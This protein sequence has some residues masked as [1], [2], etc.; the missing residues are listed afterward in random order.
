M[1]A[2]ICILASYF[3]VRDYRTDFF[4]TDSVIE[5]GVCVDERGVVDLLASATKTSNLMSLG[6]L[7]SLIGSCGGGNYNGYSCPAHK[8]LSFPSFFILIVLYLNPLYVHMSRKLKISLCLLSNFYID[9]M[10]TVVI[11]YKF[12]FTLWRHT[13]YCKINDYL[14][15]VGS[16]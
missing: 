15:V 6:W 9:I 8:E 3:I 1:N 5:L 7:N 4:S 14:Y 13:Q 12:I 2:P 16:V 11:I 10:I